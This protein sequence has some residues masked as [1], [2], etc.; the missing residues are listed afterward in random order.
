MHYILRTEK[1]TFAFCSVQFTIHSALDED[2][3][4][5]RH[6]IK[7]FLKLKHPH[8]V[9]HAGTKCIIYITF[10]SLFLLFTFFRPSLE[11]FL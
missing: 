10:T 6:G 2:K 1:H 3:D 7:P 5:L 9:Y 4:V 11:M 8:V